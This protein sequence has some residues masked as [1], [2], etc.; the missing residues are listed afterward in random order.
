MC[1]LWHAN[2]PKSNWVGSRRNQAL[3]GQRGVTMSTE[4][5]D[6]C[7]TCAATTVCC[8]WR[9]SRMGGGVQIPGAHAE[10]GQQ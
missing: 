7:G 1:P 8:E 10:S 4:R 9:C 5:M 6:G 2:Q 3:L